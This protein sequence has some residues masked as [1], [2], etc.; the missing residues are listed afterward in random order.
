MLTVAV[1]TD[2]R[3]DL[4]QADSIQSYPNKFDEDNAAVWQSPTVTLWKNGICSNVDYFEKAYV[5][6]EAGKT[7][8]TFRGQ[9]GPLID[10]D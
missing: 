2:N 9:R 10:P 1:H 3:V 5:M 7:L 8:H 4:Y 6:N